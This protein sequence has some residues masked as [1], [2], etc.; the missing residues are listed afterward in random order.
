M[1]VTSWT[2]GI[3]L[4]LLFCCTGF[5]SIAQVLRTPLGFEPVDQVQGRD[6]TKMH[7]SSAI[8]VGK[9]PVLDLASKWAADHMPMLETQAIMDCHGMATLPPNVVNSVI[10]PIKVEDQFYAAL[11]L[12]AFVGPN[13]AMKALNVD[14]R[15]SRCGY[16]GT[17]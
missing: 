15:L 7:G 16:S 9:Y 12:C 14:A 4:T 17:S 10:A 2:A 6:K 5:P 1:L 11:N 13:E 3:T 8:S